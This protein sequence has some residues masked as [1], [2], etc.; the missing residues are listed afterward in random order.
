MRGTQDPGHFSNSSS[1][2]PDG[3]RRSRAAYTTECHINLHFIAPNDVGQTRKVR[4]VNARLLKKV[5][6]AS[7]FFPVANC[8]NLALAFQHRG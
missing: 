7:S 1:L 2:D 3:G 8:V 6:P 5:S 4:Q